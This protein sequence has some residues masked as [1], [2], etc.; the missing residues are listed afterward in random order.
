MQRMFRFNRTFAVA[1]AVALF[2]FAAFGAGA[3]SAA[4][5]GEPVLITSAGQ[6]PGALMVEVLA[7]RT[8][9]EN[10]FD[11]T[12]PV[13]ALDDAGTLIVVIGASMKGLGAAGIDVN[14]EFDRITSLLMKAKEKGIA[15]IAAH[16]EGAPRRGATSDDLTEIVFEYA[17]YAVVRAD[18]DDDGFFTD[19]AGQHS[20]AL[21]TVDA[22]AGVAA[23]LQAWFAN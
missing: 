15:I 9:V 5:M 12:A 18:G 10:T 21:E 1:L 13:D 19:L 17:D 22:T 16:V 2:G 14:E 11:A 23:V 20:V 7:K 8:G 4:N 3:A 6:S